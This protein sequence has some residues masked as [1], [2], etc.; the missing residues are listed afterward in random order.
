M[1]MCFFKD[2]RRHRQSVHY[3]LVLVFS[4][5]TSCVNY[6][7]IN[8]YKKIA[9]PAQ[10]ATQ[11]SIPEQQGQ[12]PSYQWTKQ[13]EDKQL[14]NL[15]AE[16]LRNNP[17]LAV[18]RARIAQAH[19]L[20][21]GKASALF[22]LA[23]WQGSILRERFSANSYFPPPWGGAWYTQGEF[24]F[25]LNW[26][27]DLWGKNLARLRQAISQKRAVQAAEQEARI[28]LT[29]SVATTYNQL[30]YYFAL[31]EI[32]KRTVEQRYELDKLTAM[33]LKTGLGAKIQF[34]QTR[35][36]TGTALT[37][38]AAVEGQIIIARQQLSNLLGAGPDRGLAI[39]QPHLKS[40]RTP[41]LPSHLPFNLLGHR[42]DVVGARWQVEA[43]CQG[44]TNAKA[45]FYPDINL[46]ASAGF[47]AFGLNRLFEKAST[48]YVLGPAVSLPVFD[49]GALRAQLRGRYAIYEE[50]VAN[51]NEKLNNALAEVANHIASI[52]ALEHELKAQ[53]KALYSAEKAY[54]LSRKKY[55]IGLTSLLNV[56][57]SET[58]FLQAQQSQLKLVTAR[59]NGQIALIKAL[60]G[61]FSLEIQN[62][63][64]A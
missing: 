41:L 47:V 55:Q 50:A 14:G 30:A 17:S 43:A 62:E 2:K 24:L 57:E 49:A 7:G 34:Y 3:F 26:E 63:K 12:W 16:A 32:L 60:G 23:Y 33:R 31:R 6:V 51:Y 22:P 42:P 15:I 36:T 45:Q 58:E 35:T 48:Q 56:L 13:F 21:A 44:I 11:K 40:S 8:S 28:A 61:G 5:S 38:L 1:I 54:N 4:L 9:S 10:F 52:Q 46:M 37:Q 64:L 53:K 25:S 20:A 29:S 19:A 39:K 18:A 27:L 59:R